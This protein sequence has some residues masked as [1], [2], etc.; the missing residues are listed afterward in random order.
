MLF[1][2][3]SSSSLSVLSSSPLCAGG[4]YIGQAMV[5]SSSSLVVLAVL[6]LLCAHIVCVGHAMLSSLSSL[7]VLSSSS[8]YVGGGGGV[9][10][11][12]V[13]VVVVGGFVLR[14]L[15][16]DI[17]LQADAAAAVPGIIGAPVLSVL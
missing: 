7:S 2:G 12:H 16:A 11:G 5:R 15:I 3:C 13:V 10:L 9:C 1:A 6:W 14:V 4:V 8:L 17:G